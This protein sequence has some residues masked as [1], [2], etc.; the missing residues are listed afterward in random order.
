M[1]GGGILA[2]KLAYI[3]WASDKTLWPP[4]VTRHQGLPLV[5]TVRHSDDVTI[6][7]R[8]NPLQPPRPFAATASRADNPAEERWG[9][10]VTAEDFDG[11]G[12]MTGVDPSESRYWWM[13]ELYGPDSLAAVDA[14]AE[15]L[16][17]ATSRPGSWPAAAA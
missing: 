7:L 5:E 17:Q 8:K 6:M 1:G 10:F 14:A 2:G 11:T 3:A 12:I 9:G 13:P 16:T 4:S 15:P